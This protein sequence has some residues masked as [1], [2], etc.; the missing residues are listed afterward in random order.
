MNLFG[1][2]WMRYFFNPWGEALGRLHSAVPNDS[3]WSKFV[4]VFTHIASRSL[5][6]YGWSLM[7]PAFGWLMWDREFTGEEWQSYTEQEASSASGELYSPAG[8]LFGRPSDPM[9]VGDV[10]RYVYY[11]LQRKGSVPLGRQRDAVTVSVNT[12]PR[13]GIDPAIATPGRA[14]PDFLYQRR[15]TV[16]YEIGDVTDNTF[17]P[18]VAGFIP[19]SDRL[20]RAA[21]IHVAYTR[22]TAGGSHAATMS[23]GTPSRDRA[24]QSTD[25]QPAF[26]NLTIG[27]VTATVAG[28]TVTNDA[29]VTL[30]EGQRA[31][32]SV[33]PN[34]ARRYRAALLRPANGALLRLDTTGRIVAQAQA[35]SEAAQIERVYEADELQTHLRRRFVVPVREFDVTVVNAP[36]LVTTLPAN[37]DGV[38]AGLAQN[39]KPGETVFVIVPCAVDIALDV[40]AATLGG[41]KPPA[42]AGE[43]TPDGLR[44]FVGDGVI[45]RVTFDAAGTAAPVPITFK[46]TVRGDTTIPLQVTI[47][48]D[49]P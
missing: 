41:L 20:E 19:T 39:P 36:P 7:P 16:P 10:A 17:A 25:Y 45:Y 24:Q 14:V 49:P 22:P 26:F 8:R 27:D 43:A 9:V 47:T 2:G 32:V 48:V 23:Q 12:Y 15:L 6:T 38:F 30:V 4:R 11:H 44:D 5:D 3:F 29:P 34:T 40:D 13:V 21:A 33:I 35:G 31:R 46:V 1:A 42:I 37:A 18:D 28:Q